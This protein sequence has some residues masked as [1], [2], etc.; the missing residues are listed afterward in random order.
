[1]EQQIFP[2]ELC[3]RFYLK[4]PRSRRPSAINFIIRFNSKQYKFATHTKIYP[5]QWNQSLQ[6]AYISPI[7]TNADNINNSI[8]N[9]KIE[10]IKDRFTKFKL[11]LCSIAKYNSTDIVK[12]L[13]NEFN[14]MARQK[15]KKAAEEEQNKFDDIIKVIH[16]AVYND[17]TIASGTSDNYIKKGLPAL[18]FYL[19]YLEDEK[20]IKVDS[21]KYFTTEF[22][23]SFA[24]YIHDNYTYDEGQSYAIPTINSILKYAKSAIILCA[25][26]N[27]YLTEAEINSLKIKLFND[28]SSPNHI[29][30]RN[31]EVMLLYNYKPTCK[32]DEE[33]RDIFLLE[34]TFGHRITDTLR[35]DERVE[36]IGGKYY[37]TLAPK[38]TPNKKVEVGI[39]FKIA[40]EIL[41]DKYHC[42]LPSIT[43]DMINKNI[44]RIALEAGIKGEELQSFHY[45][46]ESE[47]R[48]VKRSRHECIATHTGRRT[49]ISLLV[50]RGWNY[51]QI[52]KFT[53]QTI[54]TIG[55]Y[56]KATNKYIDIYK[57]L[58]ANRPDEIVQLCD[59]ESNINH[60]QQVSLTQT[61][62]MDMDELLQLIFRTKDLF[63]LKAL[64][65]N[66]VDILALEKTAE[67]NKYLEDINRV[68]QYKQ[69][70]LKSFE[71]T[72]EE[73][74]V[75][76]IEI[77]QATVL[78]DPKLNAL[79]IA[80]T[81]LQK[82]GLNCQY[83][84]NTYKYAGKSAREAYI[85]VTVTPNG[86]IIIK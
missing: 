16:D 67:I 86:D 79:K 52:S 14:D 21:F 85:L 83:S 33:V 27:K 68:E 80:I 71:N 64:H 81:T 12:L 61:I 58:L 25:R 55:G 84:H 37:I 57:D 62:N 48:E 66:K 63:S 2:L 8:V 59:E 35:L 72:P 47:P 82:L 18:K 73:L 56:D 4:S 6:K 11:Y 54:K 26:A 42:K 1:M 15:T 41:I 19:S 13:L 20:N 45:Q 38:K 7:L 3:G 30:L 74:K 78:L 49:F 44:K 60:P 23:T 34:C 10:E 75:R 76:L 28:K 50:A 5:T 24:Y 17:T 36:E 29:A 77:L 53:G 22:L 70:I 43:K 39:I 51:E 69:Q 40:K 46:G 65:Q 32:R 31:D 9:Q